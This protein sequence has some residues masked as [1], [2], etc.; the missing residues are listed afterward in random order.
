MLRAAE[1]ELDFRSHC[2]QQLAFGFDITHL[3]NV[4]QNHRLF[5]EQSRGHSRQRG[6]LGSAD[7]NCPQQRVAAANYEFIHMQKIPVMPN[8]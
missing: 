2:S 1:A 8:A 6:V 4:F 3:R 7:A 5:S